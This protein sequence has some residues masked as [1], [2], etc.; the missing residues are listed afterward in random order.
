[1]D[2]LLKLPICQNDK[3]AQLR[4]V[5]DTVNVHIHSLQSLGLSSDQYGSLLMPVIP[6][7]VPNDISLQI[8]LKEIWSI[9]ELL[10]IIKNK[11]EAQEMCDYI[12][13]A[14]NK[15][16]TAI[17]K[18]QTTANMGMTAVFVAK[19]TTKNILCYFCL[20]NHYALEHKNVVDVTNRKEL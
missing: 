10:N 17:T 8:A 4:Y 18:S 1:M 3:P 16:L 11:V 5:Y 6:L 15:T 9:S 13:I 19:N 14:D 2:D 12:H 7:R 20:G